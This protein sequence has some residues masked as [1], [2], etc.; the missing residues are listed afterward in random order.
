[1]KRWRQQHGLS[2]KAMAAK[3]GFG[4]AT[5]SA[6]ERGTR[7][8]NG[9]A[10]SHLVIYTQTTPCRLFCDQPQ[11]CAPENCV[12]LTGRDESLRP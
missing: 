8:P 1:L 11:R 9:Y 4:V 3:L 5:V 12:F 2:L 7:F 10:L 6:W